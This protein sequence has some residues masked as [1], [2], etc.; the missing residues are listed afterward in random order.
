MSQRNR[1]RGVGLVELLVALSISA[2][3]LTA[4]GVA[5]DASFKAYAVNQQNSDLTQRS[6]LAI[7]R[8]TAMIR[9]T[10][11]HA[12]HTTALANQFA[13][14]K[15]ITDTTIDMYDLNKNEVTY[16]YDAA[17]KQLIATVKSFGGVAVPHVMCEGVETFQV[18]MEPMRSAES[19]RTGG[20]WDLLK[21]ASIVLTVKTSAATIAEGESGGTQTV[22]LSASVMPRRNSW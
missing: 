9:Q 14:G 22:T 18:R 21:R 12:P 19:I 17:K 16:S 7:Y 1:R 20:A 13:T 4:T 11:E 10:R 5:I 6:R 15:T 2:A 3:L 8:I